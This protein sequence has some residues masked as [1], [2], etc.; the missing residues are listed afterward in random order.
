MQSKD[1]FSSH[2]GLRE[3]LITFRQAGMDLNVSGYELSGLLSS[4][5][6]LAD[7]IT[8][9][10]LGNEGSGKSSFISRFVEQDISSFQSKTKL[11]KIIRY[12]DKF[13]TFSD[14]IFEEIL[15]PHQIFKK[16]NF[17][18]YNLEQLSQNSD[19]LKSVYKVSDIVFI[20]VP[21]IDPWDT[22]VYGIVSDLN[23]ITNLPSA[24]V[25]SHS[26]LRT[27]EENNAFKDYIHQSTQKALGNQM[28]V[29]EV[30]YV[31]YS[32]SNRVENNHLSKLFKWIGENVEE[33]S[34][35]TRKLNRAEKKLTDATQRIANLMEISS[36]TDDSQIE[37]LRMIEKII[38]LSSDEL[39]YEL[40]ESL[41]DD[42]SI[43]DRGID[44]TRLYI[45]KTFITL[46][47]PINYIKNCQFALSMLVDSLNDNSEK[48]ISAFRKIDSQ[49]QSCNQL[50]DTKF[51]KTLR[52]N[53]S[54]NKDHIQ[55]C[56][57]L[58]QEQTN[59]LIEHIQTN[60]EKNLECKKLIFRSRSYP[61]ILIFS[62]LCPIMTI[63]FLSNNT[64]LNSINL[65][66]ILFTVLGLTFFLMSKISK[67]FLNS[68]DKISSKFKEKLQEVLQNHYRSAGEFFFEPYEDIKK[69]L[70]ISHDGQVAKMKESRKYVMN[71]VEN[72]KKILA[73]P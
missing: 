50:D 36:Q 24:V 21:A 33:K 2:I 39:V 26:D 5:H 42:L 14:D 19:L 58:H 45:K 15:V 62:I 64:S 32:Q 67:I 60:Y 53:E 38:D 54:L 13:Q 44:N 66:L 55:K 16:L 35:F 6:A 34:R 12:G 70:R 69:T 68:F 72:A 41:Y 8:I 49:I 61:V 30:P 28:P 7:P 37:K 56:E 23:M 20:I 59:H 71:A 18:E 29:F 31:N 1:L 46:L 43:F 52:E 40:S 10:I 17:I 73:K 48:L 11:P 22:S 51:L 47:V 65:S 3:L 63:N 9:L 4:A 57:I 27:D 25:L